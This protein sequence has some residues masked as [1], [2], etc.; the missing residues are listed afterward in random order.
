MR[1]N[2]R[3]GKKTNQKRQNN[4]RQAQKKQGEIKCN[5]MRKWQN[6]AQKW[7]G[8]IRQNKMRCNE[9]RQNNMERDQA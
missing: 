3:W 1:Q 5:K 2:M 9:R 6:K 4:I 8:D 7:E